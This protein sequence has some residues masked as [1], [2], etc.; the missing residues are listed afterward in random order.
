MRIAILRLLLPLLALGRLGT[1]EAADGAGTT[2]SVVQVTLGMTATFYATAD[3]DTPATFQWRKNGN[4][5]PGARGPKLELKNIKAS[6]AGMYSAIASNSAGATASNALTISVV[7]VIVPALQPVFSPPPLQTPPVVPSDPPPYITRQPG[8]LQAQYG[9]SVMFS[10]AASGSPAPTYQWS[11]DGAQ[12]S[13]A[14]SAFLS[15]TNVS[16]DATYTVVVANSAGS[17][18]SRAASLKVLGQPAAPVASP[19]PATT[20]PV[21]VAPSFAMQ[22]IS[23]AVVEGSAV[24]F[25]I[26]ALGTPTPSL[27]WRRNGSHLAGSNSPTLQLSN[28][29]KSEEGTYDVVATNGLGTATSSGASLLVQPRAIATPEGIAPVTQPIAGVVLRANYTLTVDPGAKRTVSFMI[30]GESAKKILVRALGPTLGALGT[31]GAMSDPFIELFSGT[32][33][34]GRNDN[35]GGSSELMQASAQAG[36]TPMLNGSSR[37]AAILTTVVPGFYNALVSSAD[38]LGGTVLVEVY[39]FP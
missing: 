33:V 14:T 20:E 13:G 27:Q 4:D 21:G 32:E 7:D 37:D 39:E 34:L 3:S 17:V 18:T 26:T 2:G 24:T 29:A 9:S 28:V 15:V 1:A 36:A 35:W 5:I 22:P 8:D 11:K 6:D 16:S 10:V 25:S 23:Q 19:P 31:S 12:I 30:R 38:G